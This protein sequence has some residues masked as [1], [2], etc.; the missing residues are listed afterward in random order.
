MKTNG[1]RGSPYRSQ[2]ELIFVF[3][4]E[5][6]RHGLKTAEHGRSRREMSGNYR[7]VDPLRRS[8]GKVTLRV[9]C[10]RPRSLSRDRGRH[11]GL[12]R[13]VMLFWIRFWAVGL[14]VIA[15]E[16]AGRLCYGTELDPKSG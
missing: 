16:L 3:K 9:L 13:S 4:K 6:H 2:H 15:A 5:A 10:I 12:H 8:K 7:D 11:H 1:G 14:T